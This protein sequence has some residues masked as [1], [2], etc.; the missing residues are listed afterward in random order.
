[1]MRFNHSSRRRYSYRGS[2][3]I[4]V[5][6]V[7]LMVIVL[8]VGGIMAARVQARASSTNGDVAAA[9]LAAQSGLE[10]ARLWIAQDPNWRTSRP[11]GTWASNLA[12]GDGSVSIDVIDPVD[13]N[14]TNR[15]HD[16]V[17]LTA[18][19]TKGQATH[20]LRITLN[21]K[22]TPMPIL[23]YAMASGAGLRVRVPQKVAIGAA[24]LCLNGSLRNENVIEGNIE[25]QS[26]NTAGIIHGTLTTGAPRQAMPGSAIAES[27][28]SLGTLINTLSIDKKVLAPGVN[29][30]GAGN[31]DGV[32]VI[33]ASSSVTIRNSRINGTLVVICPGNT[34]IF[35]NV[36]F[37]HPARADFPSVI[38]N[39]NAEFRF[40][41]VG[42]N[43][44]ESAQAMNFN[45]S[46]A[47][48]AGIT[49]NDIS[50]VYPSEIRGLVHVTGSVKV[51]ASGLIRGTLIAEANSGDTIDVDAS[52]FQVIYDPTVYSNPPQFYTTSVPMPALSGSVRQ[53]VN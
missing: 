2:A 7:S 45:P 4:A 12:V 53:I 13:G 33:R 39:G 24:T 49:D 9:R 5:L 22:P 17:Q 35:D 37:I 41:S 34:V 51:S 20:V 6:G 27:Y 23:Q 3:Y 36:L 1:M 31:A 19:G 18:T 21:A 8:A 38:V 14:L 10:L 25:C 48:Y 42:A 11:S 44:S 15:P 29:P 47:P 46:G 52:T 16:P 32:Y 26:V 40:S 30:W 50:D 43:L 28:A